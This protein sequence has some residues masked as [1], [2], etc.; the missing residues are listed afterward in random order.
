MQSVPVFAPNGSEPEHATIAGFAFHRGNG[1]VMLLVA[2]TGTIIFI[3]PQRAGGRRGLDR[4]VRGSKQVGR[5]VKKWQG[6][7]RSYPF[8]VITE[9]LWRAIPSTRVP[10]LCSVRTDGWQRSV[11]GVVDEVP[12]TTFRSISSASFLPRGDIHVGDKR[13]RFILLL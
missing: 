1:P 9:L 5:P 4:S 8:K 7:H 12:C 13:K 2:P 11:A 10:R 6:S 3:E